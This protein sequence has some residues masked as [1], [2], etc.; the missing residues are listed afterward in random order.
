MRQAQAGGAFIDAGP[1][2]FT[3]RDVVE[4]IF[5]KAGASMEDYLTLKP[6]GVLARHAWEAGGELDLFA[7]MAQ[8]VDAIGAFAGADDARGY[9][10]FA[11]KPRTSTGS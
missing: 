8:T 5:E 7:D 3:M 4:R 2:V 1:T 6:A 10:S 11:A 9:L